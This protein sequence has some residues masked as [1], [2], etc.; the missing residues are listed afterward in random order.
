MLLLPQVDGFWIEKPEK[1]NSSPLTPHHV[2]VVIC[3]EVREGRETTDDSMA[4]VSDDRILAM[5]KS[6]ISSF[7]P[8]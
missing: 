5:R 1:V 2:V 6:I 7:T 3:S 4:R 8:P